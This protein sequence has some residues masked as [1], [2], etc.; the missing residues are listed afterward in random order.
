MSG[1]KQPAVVKQTREV[2]SWFTLLPGWLPFIDYRVCWQA[3]FTLW[4]IQ[5]EAKEKMTEGTK[6][7]AVETGK[8]LQTAHIALP[9]SHTDSWKFRLRL[10]RGWSMSSELQRLLSPASWLRPRGHAG[11]STVQT[12]I[13]LI[14]Q[15][16]GHAT[17]ASC[18]LW[19]VSDKVA[20]CMVH[21]FLTRRHHEVRFMI[22]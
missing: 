12:G 16:W 17:Q 7:V 10:L 13:W 21:L 19:A 4:V 15:S 20:A 5:Q 6:V 2:A 11:R 8:R 1:H 14:P 22:M 18:D 3:Y 9:L